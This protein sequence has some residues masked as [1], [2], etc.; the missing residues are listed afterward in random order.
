M[1]LPPLFRVWALPAAAAG[2]AF[3]LIAPVPALADYQDSYRKGMEAVDKANWK[4]VARY[5]RQAVGEQAKEG[6][7][8]KLYGMRFEE[9]LPSYHLGH[10]LFQAGDCGGALAAW[11]A[12]EGHGVIQKSK[13]YKVLTKNKGTCL[14]RVAQAKPVEKAPS[15]PDPAELAKQRAAEES[16]AAEQARAAEQAAAQRRDDSRRAAV[17]TPS[18]E[19]LRTTPSSSGPP[20]AVPT[21]A[22]TPAGPPAEL[23]E[24]ARA[25]FGGQYV[26]AEAALAQARYSPGKTA[27]Q[28]MLFRAAARYALFVV[29]GE[30]DTALQERARAD[31]QACRRMDPGFKPDER[32]FSPRFAKFFRGE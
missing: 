10:A 14:T 1:A 21:A 3:L 32:F 19:P 26:E 22:P 31:V 20:A 17:A 2:A 6:G 23:L 5:M 12:S 25:Y 29:G 9:Y 24:A 13:E 4:D 18:A 30:K 11:A 27:V 16:A 15:G 7:R 28:A 8:V